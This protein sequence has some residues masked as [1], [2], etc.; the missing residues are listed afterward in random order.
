MHAAWATAQ[1]FTRII[2]KPSKAGGRTAPSRLAR[3]DEIFHMRALRALDADQAGAAHKDIAVAL[4]GE[5][6]VFQRWERNSELRAQIRHL[7]R[8]GRAL[9]QGGYRALLHQKQGGPPEIPS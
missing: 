7:L 1:R 3:R 2:G 4:F 5:S 9:S 8:R 6:D